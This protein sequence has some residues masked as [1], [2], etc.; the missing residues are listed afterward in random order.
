M[1]VSQMKDVL[2]RNGSV[3][4]NSEMRKNVARLWDSAVC[5]LWCQI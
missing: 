3:Y 2:D 1:V 4:E 5:L